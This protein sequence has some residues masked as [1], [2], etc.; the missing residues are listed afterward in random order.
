MAKRYL[1][2]PEEVVKALKDGKEVR[3]KYGSIC[4]LIDGIIISK[5]NDFFEIGKPIRSVNKPYILEEEPLKLE[6]GKFYKTRG[7]DKAIVLY[8][9]DKA[10]A[11]CWPVLVA[12][13]GKANCSYSVSKT[14]GYYSSGSDTVWDIVTPWED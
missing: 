7:G 6:V 12:V 9:N 10:D 5:L 2:T 3:D 4:K 1:K 13:V 11:G 8:I 14:G